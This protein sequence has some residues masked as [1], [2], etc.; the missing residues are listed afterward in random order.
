MGFVI[1]RGLKDAGAGEAAVGDGTE[2]QFNVNGLLELGMMSGCPPG[3][4]LTCAST[5]AACWGDGKVRKQ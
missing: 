3:G 4:L 2:A 1:E 5:E